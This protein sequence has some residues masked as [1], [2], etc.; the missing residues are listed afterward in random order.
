MCD[1]GAAR[2]RM[3]K[4]YTGEPD[5]VDLT[6][7]QLNHAV[8]G[9][10]GEVGEI[11]QLLEKWVYYGQPLDRVKIG[12]EIGDVLWYV[13]EAC[14]A[15]GL[16]LGRIMEANVA[17]L[18]VRFP[19]RYTDQ[20]ADRNNRDLEKEARALG[21][22]EQVKEALREGYHPPVVPLDPPAP[23]GVDPA[24][25]TGEEDIHQVQPV[26]ARRERCRTCH[27]MGRFMGFD[28]YG[29]PQEYRCRWCG[30]TGSV[31]AGREDYHGGSHEGVK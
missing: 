20:H 22:Y 11:A 24:T 13:A 9:M 12:E 14:N 15:L 23:G 8:V 4:G 28:C 6:P 19:E 25:V 29:H 10:T 16:D 18:R 2:R 31:V 3:L 30:G 5:G 17:K 7:V 21:S 1:Q 27:G 26:A